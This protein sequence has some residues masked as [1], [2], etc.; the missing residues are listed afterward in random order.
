MST[1]R[2]FIIRPFGTRNGIDF[3]LVQ[4]ELFT[5]VLRDLGIEGSTTEILVHA[6][7]IRTDMFEQLLTADLVIA[8][9]SIH[10]ANV[11]YELGVRHAL[12]P[13][14]TILIR[15]RVDDVPFDLR[16][17][18]Y[19]TYD[20]G[21]PSA[22]VGSL[23]DA[24]TAS[25]H[26]DSADSPVFSLLPALRATDPSLLRPIP[27]AFTEA[28][29]AAERLGDR[30][31]LAVLGD[32]A[33][34]FDWWPAARRLVGRAQMD[35]TAWEDA[36][37]T[38]ESI[39]DRRP[40]DPEANLLLGTVLH[41]LGDLAGSTA[42]IERVVQADALEDNELAEAMALLARNA[43]DRWVQAWA[44]EERPAAAALA[45]P[46]LEEARQAYDDAF[47]AD[48]NHWYSGIN[49]LALVCVTLGLADREQA[50]WEGRFDDDE[51]I[52]LQ[53]RRLERLR[54]DLE[55][56]VRRSLHAS[57]V[58]GRRD[59][60]TDVWADLGRADLSLLTSPRPQ[61]VAAAYQRARA[62]LD[63]ARAG[64]FAITSAARQVRLYTALGLFGENASAALTA[65][66]TAEAPPQAL[67]RPRVIVFAGHRIDAPDRAEPRFP[68]RSEDLAATVIRDAVAAERE[69][70]GEQPLEGIAGGASGGDILFHEQCAALA[71][72]TQLLLALPAAEFAA[73]SVLDAGPDWMERFRTLC[74]RLDTK[75]LSER[76]EMPAWLAQRADYSIWSRNNRWILHT[77]LSRSE[78]DVTL[79]VLWDGAGGDGVG[80]TADMLRL[81][82]S[83]GVRVVTL[84]ASRLA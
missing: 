48:Q 77:A 72:P 34:F 7:N 12:R 25:L 79:I 53:R 62:G 61:A 71:V 28:V 16:T 6:G 36:R 50:I 73:A 65:L 69:L 14:T 35:L 67:P 58:R 47:S 39:R 55:A 23:A 11:Y 19:V 59:G 31:M 3:D 4:R 40:A 18:R 63:R 2:A 54:D 46:L 68:A 41:R 78:T 76:R 57:A 9:I 49:A 83:R 30:P 10:N 42:A 66:G 56:A 43:K 15:A 64:D 52:G 1:T 13:R 27:P 20:Q 44:G 8:D 24:I 51:E 80:G 81:A 38:L 37:A 17:D 29:R 60:T 21:D 75:V 84:D 26:T 32:E 74:R 82:R 22:S 5:P 70:A 33:G 45:S